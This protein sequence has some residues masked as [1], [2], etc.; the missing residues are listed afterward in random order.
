MHTTPAIFE[1]TPTGFP[2]LQNCHNNGGIAA[3]K[4]E[5]EKN[6]PQKERL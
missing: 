1:P 6:P 5:V 4:K 3:L 2:S